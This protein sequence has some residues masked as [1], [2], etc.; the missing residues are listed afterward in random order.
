M[1]NFSWF[2]SSKEE[3]PAATWN[4][5]TLTMEQPSSPS[6]MEQQQQQVVTEQPV[7]YVSRW[8]AGYNNGECV[9]Y[10]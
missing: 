3:A 8:D 1:F 9:G 4:P 6:S 2:K 7:C 10:P 5:Q